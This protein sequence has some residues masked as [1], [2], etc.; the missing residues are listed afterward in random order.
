MF[1]HTLN[2]VIANNLCYMLLLNKHHY[3]NMY[4]HASLPAE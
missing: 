2:Q 4:E 1:C 3:T